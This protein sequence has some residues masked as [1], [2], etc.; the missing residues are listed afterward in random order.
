[1]P[2]LDY[3][4]I[5][6]DCKNCSSRFVSRDED[7]YEQL[8]ADLTS[9]YGG[10]HLMA[11]E[12]KS[13]IGNSNAEHYRSTLFVTPKYKFVIEAIER[14]RCIKQL[15]E[16]GCSTGVLGA[17]FISRGYQ[18]TGVDVSKT[19]VESARM[20]FGPHFYLPEEFPPPD[21]GLYDAIYFV[22]T[23][24]CVEDPLGFVKQSLLKLR[25]GGL[26]I[27]NAPNVEACE[28]FGDIW[29][30][31]TT[32]P[33]LVNLFSDKIWGRHFEAQAEVF[34]EVAIERPELVIKKIVR[35]ILFGSSVPKPSVYLYSKGEVDNTEKA[36]TTDTVRFCHVRGLLSKVYHKII[37]AVLALVFG[38]RYPSEF[39]QYVIMRKR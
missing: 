20:N 26:L 36:K 15:L 16:M 10:H 34:T 6:Y 27:F 25:T 33:D 7:A 17:Y 1:M 8:H 39:G 32:P 31:G 38:A 14:E 22:G 2:Y 23:I 9:T 30:T 12:A 24:G 13:V 3:V 19:A 21:G 29:L 28:K 35:K 5:V 37:N 11:R 4:T 18:Y